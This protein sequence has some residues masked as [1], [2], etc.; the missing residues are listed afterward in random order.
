LHQFLD[1]VVGL[2]EQL[3]EAQQRAIDAAFGLSGELEPD[4]F[5]VALAAFPLVCDAAEPGPWP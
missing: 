2:T 4:P 3:S 1:P 5:R